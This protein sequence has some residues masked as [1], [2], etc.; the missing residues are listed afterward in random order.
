MFCK[1]TAHVV[2]TGP[3]KPSTQ[4]ANLRLNAV[5]PALFM[6]ESPSPMSRFSTQGIV[7]AGTKNPGC[8]AATPRKYASKPRRNVGEMAS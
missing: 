3:S 4:D 6:C 5:A 2:A 8:A 7:S 1:E